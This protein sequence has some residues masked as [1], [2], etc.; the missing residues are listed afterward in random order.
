M[1]SQSAEPEP[2][3]PAAGDGSAWQHW[4]RSPP[5]RYVIAWEQAQYDTAVAD[6]FGYHALQCG[7]REL[8]CL[9][10][11]RMP[12]RIRADSLAEPA[13]ETAA[14]S[15]I[16]PWVEPAELATV[17][18]PEQ[19]GAED[20]ARGDGAI[21]APPAAG[22]FGSANVEALP[23]GGFGG[24]SQVRIEN[25]EELPFAAQ[26]LDLVLLPHVLEFAFD[27][28]QVLREV[29]RV[30]RPEGRLMVSGF[31]PASLWG[32]RQLLMRP[33]RPAFF[34][35]DPRFI[36][37]PRLRDWL[38]LL[39]FELDGGRYGC[40]RPPCNSQRWLDRTEMVEHAGD[41]WWPILGAIYFV[42]AVK[43]VRGMRLI[44]PAW[45]TPRTQRAGAVVAPPVRSGTC[46][47]GS[48][49][50]DF[51]RRPPRDRP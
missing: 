14:D 25:F 9:R 15:R 12:N 33:F 17:P 44:G 41:R 49:V 30:L 50:V 31:N 11:N 46:T 21:A 24:I 26:S 42:S 37:L 20:D 2:P 3:M 40:Y 6:V 18:L 19:Q 28:H 5:G 39:G 45:R 16:A 35:R 32:M 13:D 38:T 43:R 51:R 47:P 29:E 22:P 8:Q 27:P 34:P 23:V 36:G 1:Q 10:A 48:T 4:L 7:L